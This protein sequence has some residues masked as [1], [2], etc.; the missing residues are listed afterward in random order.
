MD[1]RAGSL[2]GGSGWWTGGRVVWMAG[3]GGGREGG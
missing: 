3:V 1:G 2:D